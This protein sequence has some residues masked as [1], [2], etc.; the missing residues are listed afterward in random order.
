MESMVELKNIHKSFGENHILKGV[1]MKIKKGEVVVILGPSGSGKTTLL[2]TINFLDSADDGSVSVHDFKVKCKKH[3]KSQVIELR[4]KT[5]M[6]FQNYNLFQNKT[7]LQNVMEGL[8]TVKKYKKADAEVNSR[9][10]LE[11]VGLSE[12]C[13]FYPSQLSGGQQQRAGIARALILDPDVI[14]FDEPTSALDPELVGEVL[15]TIKVVA[16]TGITMIVVTHEIS[17]AREV[18]SRVIFMEGGVVVEEG[19]PSEILVNPKEA[20]TQQFLQRITNPDNKE[21]ETLLFTQ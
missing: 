1:D 4:R 5:A 18:A 21:E 14:L 3:T 20:R 2:R 7:I 13:D 19:P 16:K 6:V 12:R 9:K 15:K 17:F 10:I 8:V 11:K